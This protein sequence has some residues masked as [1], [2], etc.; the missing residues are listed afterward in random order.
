M[1]DHAC[2]SSVLGAGNTQAIQSAGA[3]SSRLATNNPKEVARVPRGSRVPKA[4][5]TYPSGKNISDT[6]GKVK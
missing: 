4:T 1:P 3:L 6:A 5:L 2:S